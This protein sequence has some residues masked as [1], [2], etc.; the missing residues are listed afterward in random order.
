MLNPY[1]L[2]EP[3]VA[4]FF[5]PN[6]K[7]ELEKNDTELMKKTGLKGAAPGGDSWVWMTAY[8]RLKTSGYQCHWKLSNNY[9]L[10][11][12]FRSKRLRVSVGKLENIAHLVPL[13]C[14]SHVKI[15][16]NI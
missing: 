12:E 2:S 7:S 10:F 9:R 16:C 15:N 5:H 13:D 3:Q 14:E 6:L 4:E 1:F 8:S 11:L